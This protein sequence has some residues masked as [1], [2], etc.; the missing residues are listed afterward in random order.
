MAFFL[1]V[2]YAFLGLIVVGFAYLCCRWYR[3]SNSTQKELAAQPQ[4]VQPA[5]SLDVPKATH[6][7]QCTQDGGTFNG[8]RFGGA[9]A[10]T[11][12][13][14]MQAPGLLVKARATKQPSYS[15]ITYQLFDC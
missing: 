14:D 6:I 4:P 11:A 3:K 10:A 8:V 2:C 13:R 7:L 15:E 9:A 1:L 5:T 12:G